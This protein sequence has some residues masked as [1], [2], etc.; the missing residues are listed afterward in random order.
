MISDYE[1]NYLMDHL[2]LDVT[3]IAYL[4]M[5]LL[6][7]SINWASVCQRKRQMKTPTLGLSDCVPVSIGGDVFD[8]QK[9]CL[10]CHDITP[11]ILPNLYDPKVLQQYRVP[12]SRVTT[13]KMGDGETYKQYLLDLCEKR[14]D[15]LGRIVRNR[16]IGAPSD[17]H[18]ADAKY[19]RSCNANIHRDATLQNHHDQKQRFC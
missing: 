2:L 9:H 10:F 16:I 1:K 14:A 19:H 12:A 13:D 11:C 15:E 4:S 5:Y 17:L 18:A 8:F 7:L 3:K 6:P